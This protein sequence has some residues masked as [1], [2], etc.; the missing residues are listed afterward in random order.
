MATKDQISKRDAIVQALREE[1]HALKKKVTL[2]AYFGMKAE[3]QVFS[4]E[5]EKFLIQA[6][7]TALDNE[8][9]ALTKCFSM[10]C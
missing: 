1:F 7:V 9:R 3:I 10:S 6:S 2:D 5:I 8:W 4:N